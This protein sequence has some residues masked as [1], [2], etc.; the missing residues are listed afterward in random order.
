MSECTVECDTRN[1]VN[2]AE[3]LVGFALHPCVMC[4]CSVT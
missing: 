2:A 4:M 1:E 3:E